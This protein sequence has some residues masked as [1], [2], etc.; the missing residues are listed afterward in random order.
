MIYFHKASSN[1]FFIRVADLRE[2][3]GTTY[4]FTFKHDQQKKEFAINLEDSSQYSYRYSKFTLVLP[5]DLPDMKMVGEYQF[6]CF[7]DNTRENL[8]YTGKMKLIG[9]PRV[10]AINEVITGDNI[11]YDGE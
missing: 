11:I 8:L 3:V 6:K 9:T 5:A 4:Y 10:E 7:E 1:N 2:N